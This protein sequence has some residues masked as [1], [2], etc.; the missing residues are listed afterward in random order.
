MLRALSR[1]ADLLLE[2]AERQDPSP[3]TYLPP[4]P[5]TAPVPTAPTYAD[6]EDGA[7][8]AHQAQ[9]Q[10]LARARSALAGMPEAQAVLTAL[11]DEADG[12]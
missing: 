5:P 11:L 7:T 2:E 4:P 10:A 3:P 8:Q 6:L 1:F 9:V 12:S